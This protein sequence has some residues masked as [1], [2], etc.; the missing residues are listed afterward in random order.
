MIFAEKLSALADKC[1]PNGTKAQIDN[2]LEVRER[3][4]FLGVL[5]H[6]RVLARIFVRMV[7][8]EWR[9]ILFDPDN[10]NGPYWGAD[11]ST[12]SGKDAD[13][14]L[15]AVWIKDSVEWRRCN[16]TEITSISHR[17]AHVVEL[18]HKQYIETAT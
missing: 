6:S 10:P 4:R 11:Y 8:D 5:S 3:R 14:A 12:T 16:S 2:C 17:I 13:S 1:S 9:I 15:L 18:A 7:N